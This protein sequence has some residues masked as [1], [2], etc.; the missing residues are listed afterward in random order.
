VAECNLDIN[1]EGLRELKRVIERV[2][3]IEGVRKIRIE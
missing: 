3:N 2:N 1:F